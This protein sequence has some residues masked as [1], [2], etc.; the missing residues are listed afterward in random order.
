MEDTDD[1]NLSALHPIK[2]AMWAMRKATDPRTEIR[3]VL[4]CQW[5]FAKQREDTFE[6][7]HMVAGCMNAE[8][9]QAC[10][11]NVLEIILRGARQAQPSHSGFAP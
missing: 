6:P 10:F 11:L 5:A 7:G 9:E 2:Q 3:S 1:Q 8:L 4:T